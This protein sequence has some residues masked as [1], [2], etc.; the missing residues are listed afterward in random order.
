M[1][2][3]VGGGWCFVICLVLLFACFRLVACRFHFEASQVFCIIPC[4]K[5]FNRTRVAMTDNAQSSIGKGIKNIGL[6]GCCF[7]VCLFVGLLGCWFVDLLA[8]WFVGLLV[9]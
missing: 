2:F 6:L 1:S 8:C 3:L 5:L 4:M 9:C 7:L